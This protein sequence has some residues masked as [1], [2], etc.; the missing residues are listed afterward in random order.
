MRHAGST[1]GPD[2][3]VVARLLFGT[4]NSITEWYTPEGP[5]SPDALADTILT[6]ALEGLTP[7]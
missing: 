4:I 7:R 6:L 3:A 1:R 2:P 5:L